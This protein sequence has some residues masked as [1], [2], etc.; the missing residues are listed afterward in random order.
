MPSPRVLDLLRD[1]DGLSSGQLYRQAGEPAGLARPVF[2]NLVDGLARANLV[3][4]RADSFVKD[5]RT[6]RFQRVWLTRRSR[7]AGT[8]DV[9]EVRLVETAGKAR[10]KRKTAGRKRGAAA[11]SD[12]TVPETVLDDDEA[13]LF[14]RL[15]AWRLEEARRRRVPAFR[16]LSDRTLAAICRARPADDEELLEVAG[17]GPALLRKFGRKVLAVVN[18]DCGPDDD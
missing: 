6:I 4:V 16:I 12:R 10:P 2:E 9:D 7:L 15:R 8:G 11:K 17:I 5:G 3:D 18:A 13:A 1:R 14:E